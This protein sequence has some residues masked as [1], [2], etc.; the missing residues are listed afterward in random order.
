M[1]RNNFAMVQEFMREVE[2]E[3]PTRPGL[4]GHRTE[5]D[6]E[7]MIA[8]AE[9]IEAAIEKLELMRPRLLLEEVAEYL[10][11]EAD[12]DL[13]G[14][15]K[16]LMD[17]EY[18]SMGT[19]NKYGIPHDLVF[20]QIHLLNMAKLLNGVHFNDRGKV[21]KPEGYQE[22]DLNEWL[23]SGRW[24]MRQTRVVNIKSGAG[25]EVHIGRPSVW[26]NP[27]KIG[28]DGDRAEVLGKFRR[29]LERN[30]QLVERAR[31]ELKG[32]VLG[33]YCKPAPCHGD[34]WIE[35]MGAW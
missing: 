31:R 17:I 3:P 19:A 6:R 14:V 2:G 22:P 30:P 24:K 26:G 9:A 23:L 16:E 10:R 12:M 5:A 18:V 11:A 4:N 20:E 25:Y 34:I 7:A 28:Q 13:G 32:R 15:A 27:Y 29:Y 21:L 8:L 33:C 35:F 1:N